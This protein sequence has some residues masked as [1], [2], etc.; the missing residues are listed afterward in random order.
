MIIE[1]ED[2]DCTD[3]LNEAFIQESDSPFPAEIE[4]IVLSTMAELL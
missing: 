4:K 1:S 3:P 2:I